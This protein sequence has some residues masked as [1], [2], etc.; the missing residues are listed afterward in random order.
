M[1]QLSLTLNQPDT[2]DSNFPKDS[3]I[4]CKALRDLPSSLPATT[5]LTSLTS[6]SCLSHPLPTTL[7]YLL[8]FKILGRLLPQ[9]LC[10][11]SS[12]CLK[13]SS[14][15]YGLPPWLA[16]FALCSNVTFSMTILFKIATQL[17]P[18]NSALTFFIP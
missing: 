16:P 6:S 10:T 15:R 13:C 9:G 17:H 11:G 12:F 5:Q 1:I 8:F 3:T 4:A 14:P 18:S 7:A 2:N